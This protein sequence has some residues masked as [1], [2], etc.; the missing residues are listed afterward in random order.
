MET[1]RTYLQLKTIPVSQ[2]RTAFVDDEDFERVSQHKWSL[3]KSPHDR[4]EY[5]HRSIKVN[6]KWRHISLHRFIMNPP[7]GVKIDHKDG[8]GLNCQRSNMRECTHQQNLRNRRTKN[9][10]GLKGVAFI[11]NRPN[12]QWMA[13][14][15]IDEGPK[16]IGY[17]STALQAAAAYN[18]MAVKHFG[19][20]AKLNPL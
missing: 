8:H 4:T 11:K 2:G 19:E 12:R 10:H 6:G 18:E 15:R 13:K 1:Q 16:T 5:A 7:S 20:F 3:V 9:K 14:I 17:Y